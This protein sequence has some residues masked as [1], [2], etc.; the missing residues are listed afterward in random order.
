MTHGSR[1]SNVTARIGS[2]EFFEPLTFM[3]PESR[4]PP[5]I[6][7][8]SIPREQETYH[9]RV[10]LFGPNVAIIF[11]RQRRRKHLAFADPDLHRQYSARPKPRRRLPNQLPHQLVPVRACEKRHFG[12]VQHFAR[13]ILPLFGRNVRKIRDDQI[14][15][16]LHTFKQVASQ[17]PDTIG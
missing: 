4:R 5:W 3:E 7:I 13:K 10:I 11:L 14:E 6:R 9:T 15:A 16:W 12:I 2:E 17:E 1:V 8:L